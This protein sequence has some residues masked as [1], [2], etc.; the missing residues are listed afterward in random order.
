[1]HE[2]YQIPD[3]HID[4]VGHAGPAGL[5]IAVQGTH[6]GAS[7]PTCQTKSLSVHSKYHRLH[8]FIDFGQLC[9]SKPAT[10]VHGNRPAVF[11]ISASR[12]HPGQHTWKAS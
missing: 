11:M 1:M 4:E 10:D 6:I 9:S 8:I 3:C 5:R 7:C 12:F 2:L